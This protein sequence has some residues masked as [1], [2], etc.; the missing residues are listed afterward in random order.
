MGARDKTTFPASGPAAWKATAHPVYRGGGGASSFVG[1][2][3]QLS[4]PAVGAW[5]TDWRLTMDFEDSPIGLRRSN[6]NQVTDI[7]FDL[8]GDTD[9]AAA[10]AHIGGG[11]GFFDKIYDQIA[12]AD[13]SQSTSANQPLYSLVAS[14]DHRPAAVH[15]D[16]GDELIGQLANP[17]S[18]NQDHCIVFVGRAID[19]VPT[20][21]IPSACFVGDPSAS[22]AIGI[23]GNDP[24][25]PWWYGGAFLLGANNT[26]GSADAN[27]HIF[28]KRHASGTTSFYVDGAL[29]ESATNTYNFDAGLVGT[30]TEDSSNG[31][32]T[33]TMA[34]FLLFAQDITNGDQTTAQNLCAARYGIALV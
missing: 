5:S 30:N 31:P 32:S 6:D 2:L 4:T 12:S 28:V 11:S 20:G 14:L 17:F 21:G 24:G 13:L 8:N 7:P 3:D 15:Q 34:T 33:S 27:Y 25:D 22:S 10:A 1:I 29:V 18:G 16:I 9:T 23:A 19:A 26:G